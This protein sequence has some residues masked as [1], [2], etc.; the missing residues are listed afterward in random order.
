MARYRSVLADVKVDAAVAHASEVAKVEPIVVWTWHR[1]VA[2]MVAG[3]LEG[4]QLLT[5]DVAPA[6]RE[7]RLRAWRAQPRGVLV[8]TISVGQVGIDLSHARRE[9]FVEVDYTPAVVAQAE[10][11][12]Y[13]P[14][15]PMYVS[16]LVADHVADRR[17]VNALVKKLAASAPLGVD[18]AAESIDILR[19]ILSPAVET[20][21]LERLARDLINTSFQ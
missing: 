2:E 1:R 18:A 11:R 12:T 4:A 19:E 8:A 15:R 13:S 5:G 16:F 20:A 9:L 10:M 14:A 3:R 6:E 21:D 17:V 7:A